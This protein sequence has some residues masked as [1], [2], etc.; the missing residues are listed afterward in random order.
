MSEMTPGLT[1]ATKLLKQQLADLGVT[2]TITQ[3]DPTTLWSN[4]DKVYASQMFTNYFTNRP[5]AMTLPVY[6]SPDSPYNFSQWK[7]PAYARALTESQTLT[8]PTARARALTRAQQLLR[9]NGGDIVWGYQP[10]LGAH[11]NGVKGIT[12]TQSVP[13]FA[14]A[15]FTR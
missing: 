8:D 4:L 9:D 10:N 11:V 5:P 12:T 6:Q 3:Q 7:D 14:K 13:L 2:L 15:T 1:D